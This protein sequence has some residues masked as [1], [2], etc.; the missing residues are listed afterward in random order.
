MCLAESIFV[1]TVL[2][3]LYTIN[4]YAARPSAEASGARPRKS[5]RRERPLALL[6]TWNTHSLKSAQL[7]KN[8]PGSSAK[9]TAH[10]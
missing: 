5:D 8:G 10:S 1:F 3:T 7:T 9:L 4:T 6:Y 2:C